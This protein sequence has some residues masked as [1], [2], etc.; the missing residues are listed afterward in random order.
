MLWEGFGAFTVW[1]VL[2]FSHLGLISAVIKTP[3]TFRS[4]GFK[5]CFL[6]ASLSKENCLPLPNIL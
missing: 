2:G 3:P 4:H 5:L 1:R 6:V